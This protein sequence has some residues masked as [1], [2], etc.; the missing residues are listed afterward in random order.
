MDPR[1]ECIRIFGKPPSVVV[2]APGRVNLIGE[3]TDYNDGF[4]FPMTV[5]CQIQVA[6][7][8]RPDSVLS[9]H[10]VDYGQ[11]AE[12]SMETLRPDTEH[13]WANYP[14]GVFSLLKHEGYKVGGCDLVFGGNIPQ[15]S[16]LS[17]S[18]ALEVATALAVSALQGWDWEPAPMAKLCQ[19]AENEFVGVKCGIMDLMAVAAAQPGHALFLDC[20]SLQ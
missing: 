6:A 11:K 10:S 14:L 2:R 16:G 18:P 15:G 7:R 20:R 5:D 1:A 13:A 19:R 8:S 4:V 17:S 3:H 12:S 9:L